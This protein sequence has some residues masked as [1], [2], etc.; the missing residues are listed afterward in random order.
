MMPRLLSPLAAALLLA[1]PAS[2]QTLKETIARFYADTADWGVHDDMDAL[3]EREPENLEV[4]AWSAEFDLRLSPERAATTAYRVLDRAPCN[5]MAHNVVA[6][7]HLRSEDASRVDSAWTHAARAV[8]CGPEDGNAWLTYWDAATLLGDGAAEDRAQRQLFETGFFPPPVLEFARWTLNAAPRDAV[9]LTSGDAEFHPLQ[10]V[11]TALNVRPDV[12]I[13]RTT[14]L[15]VPAYARRMS[16]AAMYPIAPEAE[17]T[18]EGAPVHRDGPSALQ[19]AVVKA[20]V[21][22][23]LAGGHKPLALTAI[24][25]LELAGN[26][27]W[28]LLRRAGP[29]VTIHPSVRLS[30]PLYAPEAYEAA[31]RDLDLRRLDGPPT[32]EGDRSPVRRNDLHPSEIVLLLYAAYA[33]FQGGHDQPEIARQALGWAQ[34]VMDTGRPRADFQEFLDQARRAIP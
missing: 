31:W 20:W 34:Q 29:V 32:S 25:N 21:D 30:D 3:V 33:D 16:E 5:A 24:T 1:A 23:H 28:G 18:D 8:E 12:I 9:L 26:F 17:G 2:A 4:L 13:V 22:A 10:V 6:V 27:S 19:Q 14:H 11:Q 7:A 15:N